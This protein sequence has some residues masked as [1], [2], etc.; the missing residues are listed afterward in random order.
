MTTI[1]RPAHRL[2]QRQL[3]DLFTFGDARRAGLSQRAFYALR[4]EG[5]IVAIAHG[6]YRQAHAD[7]G[8]V[9]LIEIAE[10][11]QSATLRLE[12]ALSRHGL[13]DSI[14]VAIDIAIPRGSTRPALTAS[15][16]L[17]SFDPSTF[18]LRRQAI[19]IG[20]RQPLHVYSPERSIVDAVRLRQ[21]QG[22]GLASKSSSI[23]CRT[24]RCD[25]RSS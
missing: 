8:D 18:E 7:V 10:R 14:P 2:W 9:D 11:A 12:T 20:T 16:R 23:D 15:T 21:A 6:L 22:T 4:D 17:H 25:V 24:L 5:A 13:V 19:D 3:G 1:G